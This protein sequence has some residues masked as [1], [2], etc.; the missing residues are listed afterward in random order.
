[1]ESLSGR[2]IRG[3]LWMLAMQLTG[4]LFGAARLLILARLLTPHDFGLVGISLVVLSLINSFSDTGTQLALIRRPKRARDLFD[5]AW[6]LG[7]IRG[8]VVAGLMISLAPAVG[9]FFGSPEAVAIVRGMAFV[10]LIRG[11]TNI[12]IVEFRKE[13]ALRRHYLLN[14]VAAVADL[15][16]AVPLAL[17]LGNA[18]ALVGGWLALAGARAAMSYI[19]HPYRPIPRL[20]RG[21][22][23][24]LF[25][26]GRWVFGSTA[27]EWLLSD[28]VQTVVARLLGVATLGLYQMGWRV[29]SLPTMQMTEVVS[30][31]TVAA[32]AKLQDSSERAR[33][34]YLRV[35]RV[36]AL[37][38]I[39]IGVGIEVHAEGLVRLLLGGRWAAIVP[40]IQVLALFGVIRSLARTTAPLFQGIG[41][42]KLQTVV[43]G[44]ELGV[45]AALLGPLT[46]RYGSVGTAVAVTAGSA[47]GAGAAL[48]AARRVL[49]DRLGEAASLL[50]WPVFACLPFAALRVWVLGPVATPLGLAGAIII[51][52]LLYLATL[53]VLDRFK[54]YALG[55]V[56]PSGMW[57]G[58]QKRVRE[59]RI[60]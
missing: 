3:G 1:M 14:A 45:L 6:T 40:M 32:Y 9:M 8:G 7:L 52:G 57:P 19:L 24:E 26:Y 35:L 36:V 16:A 60:L 10:P 54:L 28:G 17:W 58:L 23:R 44:V 20:D 21:A 25:A 37:V 33:H 2:V 31:V 4:Y 30:G 22:V 50:G 51:S 53:L 48:W 55:P 56:V 18:W 27:I 42:P 34:A 49:G 11:L 59:G 13:L 41:R 5:T 15:C 46:I 12:G 39:P 38:A 29:A 43:A 47:A